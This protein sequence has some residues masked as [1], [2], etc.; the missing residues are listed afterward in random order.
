MYTCKDCQQSI[1]FE[2]EYYCYWC[3]K[4]ICESCK[5]HI[6]LPQ[7]TQATCCTKCWQEHYHAESDANDT[8]MQVMV[9]AAFNGHDLSEWLTTESDDGWQST[10]RLCEKAVWVGKNGLQYSSLE[11]IC[12]MS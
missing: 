3:G 6:D 1:K 4:P 10:C 11:N 2:Q 5:K 12:P 7:R 8:R 9:N